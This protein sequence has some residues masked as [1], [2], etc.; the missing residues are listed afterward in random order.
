MIIKKLLNSEWY[1]KKL[2]KKYI[3]DSITNMVIIY[4]QKMTTA[5]ALATSGDS[6][7]LTI[8]AEIIRQTFYTA[9]N[10]A[11]G[12]SEIERK[13]REVMIDPTLLSPSAKLDKMLD[14]I[15]QIKSKPIT[16]FSN[17]TQ[18]PNECENTGSTNKFS[19]ETYDPSKNFNFGKHLDL[20]D[21]LTASTNRS[22][23]LA[24]GIDELLKKIGDVIKSDLP[25]E[26]KVSK[27]KIVLI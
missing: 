24:D 18:P 17:L 20:L 21:F 10:I 22:N 11:S 25:D 3:A 9:T 13:L 12:C 16:D 7:T 23:K 5:D 27:I 2:K 6:Q 8:T 14:L 1:D 26:T 19:L 4:S 15:L